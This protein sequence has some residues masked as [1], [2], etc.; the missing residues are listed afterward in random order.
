VD[1]GNYQFAFSQGM[2]TTG[3]M[4]FFENVARE[5]Q[6]EEEEETIPCLCGLGYSIC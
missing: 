1:I 3:I 2:S 6:S 5:K 4:F